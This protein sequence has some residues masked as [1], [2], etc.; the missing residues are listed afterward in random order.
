MPTSP[1]LS[2]RAAMAFNPVEGAK[3]PTIALD[4]YYAIVAAITDAEDFEDLPINAQMH[5]LK[6]E[7]AN[8]EAIA[9]LKKN[10]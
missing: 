4:E 7:L 6:C 9:A 10:G 8:A 2:H 1:R 5:I 3:M